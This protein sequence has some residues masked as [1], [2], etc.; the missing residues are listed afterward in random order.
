[1]L[2]QFRVLSKTAH[3]GSCFVS[4]RLG[5][6]VLYGVLGEAA[7]TCDRRGGPAELGSP[8]AVR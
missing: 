2:S 7:V 3:R 6:S 4:A 8:R 1:M 5:E